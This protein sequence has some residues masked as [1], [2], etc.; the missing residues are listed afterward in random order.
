MKPTNLG[1]SVGI[2]KAKNKNELIKAINLAAKYDEKILAEEAVLNAREIECAVLGNE[3]PKASLP[4]EVILHCDF[5]DYAAKYLSANAAETKVPA[6][7]S[8]EITEK[9]RDYSVRAF[10]AL[11]CAGMLRVDFFVLKD[12]TI[13]INEVNPIPGFTNISMYPKMWG[14]SGIAYRDLVDTLIQLALER[15][16]KQQNYQ[17][18]FA[19]PK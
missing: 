18:I 10:K 1:S 9:I 6:D 2:S 3:N 8:P 17:R 11:R 4:A 15:Y 14:A 16:K 12:S 7:L 13:Y 19:V 5:Y